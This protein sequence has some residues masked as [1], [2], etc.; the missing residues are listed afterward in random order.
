MYAIRSYYAWVGGSLS[1][2]HYGTYA[3]YFVKY[4]TA[5]KNQ[6][7]N[8]WA[9]TVQNEPENGNAEPS[10]LM[11]SAEQINFINNNL[12]P[13]L[14]GA[15]FSAVKIIAYDHNCGNTTYPIDVCKNS[16]YVDG[17]AFH[18]YSGDISALTTVKNS[19]GKNVYFTEQ[20]TA[21]TGDFGGDFYWHFKN[22]LFGASLNWAKV[23][24]E[25]NLANNS[26]IGPHTPGGCNTCQGAVTINNSTSYNY[27]LSYYLVGQFSKFVKSG[28]IRL[29]T[30]V[31]GAN[32]LSTAFQNT[33]GTIVTLVYNMNSSSQTFKIVSGTQSF[34]YTLPGSTVASFVWQTN[35]NALNDLKDSD[36]FLYPNPANNSLN[37]KNNISGQTVKSIAFVTM[38]G[39]V[40]LQKLVDGTDSETRINISDLPAGVYIA[41]IICEGNSFYQRVI[42]Q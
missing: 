33:D 6:G 38:T 8:I 17:A 5:M 25:W 3:K 23:I 32:V 31:A 24:L 18:L 35:P 22:V 20:Y 14:A 37:I 11:S 21:S 16:G 28:A 2:A 4:L 29:S 36:L 7:I 1:S 13:Q 42:K 34:V 15:G 39:K 30:S 12:G 10:M 9:I 26:S 27:N 40:V 41:K 19:T